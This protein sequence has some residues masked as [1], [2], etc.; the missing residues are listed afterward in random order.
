VPDSVPKQLQ[1]SFGAFVE[2]LLPLN[3]D[4]AIGFDVQAT[5]SD[6][7]V[8]ILSSSSYVQENKTPTAL[9]HFL[10]WLLPLDINAAI[11]F[12]TQAAHSS[13][14]V[15]NI[16]L[17]SIVRLQTEHIHGFS[18]FFLCLLSL[19]KQNVGLIDGE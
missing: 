13:P 10:D 11:G 16:A 15:L 17:A 9:A 12:D 14:Q 6:S 5:H 8:L 1:V 3:I 2:W 18:A 7:Q 19:I 4:A